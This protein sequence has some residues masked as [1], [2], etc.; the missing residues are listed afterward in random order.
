MKNPP[1][2]KKILP[3][4]KFLPPPPLSPPINAIWKTLIYIYIYIMYVC[5]LFSQ[6]KVKS[7]IPIDI[8][9]IAVIQR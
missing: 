9:S 2:L 4:A 6:S 3:P 5:V 1:Q 7:Y 8:G